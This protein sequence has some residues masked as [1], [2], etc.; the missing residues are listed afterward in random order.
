M[1]KPQQ[2]RG[3]SKDGG[4][5]TKKRIS[6]LTEEQITYVDYKDVN[7]LKK[8]TSERAKMRAR[9]VTGNNVQQQ[10]KVVIAIKNAREMALLPYASRVTTQRGQRGD[11]DRGGRASGP[12]PRPSAPPPGSADEAGTE[13]ENFDLPENVTVDANTEGRGAEA[14]AAAESTATAEEATE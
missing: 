2:K 3:K 10:R 5:R 11:R 1:A 13:E 8:F 4:R 14:P 7:L 6:P 12:P 9:R